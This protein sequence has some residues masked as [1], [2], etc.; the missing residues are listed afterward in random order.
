MIYHQYNTNHALEQDDF[1]GPVS[2]FVA[3]VILEHIEKYWV[4]LE[5]GCLPRGA[6]P[7]KIEILLK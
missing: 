3:I 1:E 5:R 7:V 2:Q 4:L 6:S